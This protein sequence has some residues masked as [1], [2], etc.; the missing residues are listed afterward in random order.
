MKLDDILKE[1]G[2]RYGLFKDNALIAQELKE[3]MR[4]GIKWS[5]L[6]PD[7]KE[8]L[9][10]FAAKISRLLTGDPDYADNWD[11]IAGYA[12]LVAGRLAT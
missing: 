9:D 1:R 3:V 12:K 10:M 7:Q 11:D 2:G 4:R 6:A 5:A 8:A